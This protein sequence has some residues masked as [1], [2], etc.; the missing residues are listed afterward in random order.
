MRRR[1]GLPCFSLTALLIFAFPAGALSGDS[2][3]LP[4][5]CTEA[6][7]TVDMNNCAGAEFEKADAELNR[8]YKEA[9]ASIPEMAIDE[10]PF[11]KASW[12]EALR[13]S[14]RAWIAF[15]DAECEDHVEKFWGG[16]S[17]RTVD[18][19]GCKTEKTEQ[20]TKEL[21]QRYEIE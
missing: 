12:E 2:S 14:Q 9:I 1:S 17:G 8:V 7:S 19:I 15:R 16:G 11:D 5:D 18:I 21:K 6:M 4:A 10:Q 13:A 20:R 3:P